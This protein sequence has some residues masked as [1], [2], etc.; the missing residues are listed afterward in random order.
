MELTWNLRA[1][2]R[3]CRESDGADVVVRWRS[4]TPAVPRIGNHCV[5]VRAAD[6]R[7]FVFDRRG[8]PE[9]QAEYWFDRKI[10]ELSGSGFRAVEPTHADAAYIQ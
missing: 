8:M 10:K 1:M 9:A 4:H 5:D 2:S 6:G 7:C 3:L